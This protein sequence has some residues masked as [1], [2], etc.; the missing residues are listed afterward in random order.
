M[1][2]AT[3]FCLI[4]SVAVW[5]KD[6]SQE[7]GEVVVPGGNIDRIQCTLKKE[8][9]L[10][11]LSLKKRNE[12]A[13]VATGGLQGFSMKEKDDRCRVVLSHKFQDK[14][15]RIG[16][17]FIFELHSSIPN[18]FKKILRPK[19]L[20]FTGVVKNPI[21][22]ITCFLAKGSKKNHPLHMTIS[23]FNKMVSEFFTCNVQS[24][25]NVI[26]TDYDEVQGRELLRVNQA[27][28]RHMYQ[29]VSFDDMESVPF[30]PKSYTKPKK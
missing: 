6:K 29:K 24:T 10:K 5:S 11:K 19:T 17:E 21:N 8:I 9:N 1:R 25:F 20:R 28:G 23:D 2:F 18:K 13:I 12:F 27:T 16:S 30:N 7:T 26:I 22:N 4:F 15:Q 14:L 3:L